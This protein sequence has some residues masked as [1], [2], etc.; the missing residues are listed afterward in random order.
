MTHDAT[1]SVLRRWA[2]RSRPSRRSL[3]AA[4]GLAIVAALSALALLGGS[5]VLV[6]RATG[7]GGLAALGG[8]LIAIELMAFLRAPLRLRERLTAHR[9][10]LDSMVRWRVWLYDRI[11]ERTPGG[12]SLSSGELLDRSI[13]DVDALQDLYVRI[14]LPLLSAITAGL[15]AALWIGVV[16]ASAGGVLFAALLIGLGV[17]GLIGRSSD[18]L[19]RESA[20][21]R[22]TLAGVTTDFVTGMTELAMTDGTEGSLVTIERAASAR[23]RLVARQAWI[24]GLGTAALVLLIGASIVIIAVLAG[25]AVSRGALSGAAAAGITLLAVAGLEPLSGLIAAA[26]RS[27]E[28]AASARRLEAVEEPPLSRSDLRAPASW[29]ARPAFIH[30][31]A[32]RAAPTGRMNPVLDGAS[33]ELPVGCRVALLGASGAGKS[34]LAE[35]VLSFLRPI[36]GRVMVG[37]IDLE[38]ISTDEVL[39]H[40]ALLDQSSTIFGGSLR[41]ALR[42][43]A[44]DA[45]DA[46]MTAMLEACQLSEL[47]ETPDGLG[48][49]LS[50]QGASLS[51]GQQ[52]RLALA[53]ALLRQP[54]LLILDEPTVGLDPVQAG[55]VLDVALAAAGPAS[56]LLITHDIAEA[57][58]CDSVVWLSQGQIRPLTADEIAGLV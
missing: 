33:L 13:D 18:H 4:I 16:L 21:A 12:L 25:H 42:L 39:R 20:A 37:T 54:E 7:G 57:M 56:V 15:V 36:S 2:A 26:L 24:R 49:V 53:R 17:A 30:V 8:L 46:M 27:P 31:Q 1:S 38:D 51:G 34:T 47:L 14:A 43:G 23:S 10:A 41:D 5:G 22:S 9:V 3:A 52:Q 19:E 44:P 11:A 50:E 55:E 45:S 58:R 48:L 35:V 40:I 6:V 32:V 29:P 28:V